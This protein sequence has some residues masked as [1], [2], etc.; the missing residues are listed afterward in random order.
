MSHLVTVSGVQFLCVCVCVFPCL[1]V[2]NC[3]VE[4]VP[5]D[6]RDL[7]VATIVFVKVWS[8]Q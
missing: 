5:H 6:K 4:A 7:A 2:G 8:D 3:K 1:L